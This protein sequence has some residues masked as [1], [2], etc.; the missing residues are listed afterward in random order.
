[1][2]KPIQLDFPARNHQA[3]LQQRLDSAPTEHAA[4]LL[5]F[6]EL[7]EV[8]HQQKV[9]ST[10]RGAVAASDDLVGQL[11][12]AA[13]EP[14]TIRAFRNFISLT[15]IFGQIDPE[16]FEAVQRSI[17]PQLKDRDLRRRT[18]P[19]S[20]WAIARTLW[21]PPVRRVLFAGGLMLAGIGYYMNKDRPSTA[22]Q[23]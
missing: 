8:L 22:D 20:L 9:L 7:I 6:Y 15:K 11:A 1:M 2:A 5:E 3:E 18:P 17:P 12:K 4:A 19:P 16:L 23:A 13:A 10:L 14:E 21:S